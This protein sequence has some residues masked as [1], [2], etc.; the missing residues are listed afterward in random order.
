MTACV[1]IEVSDASNEWTM[2]HSNCHKVPEHRRPT[3]LHPDRATAER[4]AVRLSQLHPHGIFAIF[5]ARAIAQ[6]V[7]IPTH[8]TFGGQVVHSNSV[9]A[10]VEIDNEHDLPF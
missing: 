6:R 4:E 8:V 10:R 3:I 5:E 7:T 2:Q 1:I 9:P